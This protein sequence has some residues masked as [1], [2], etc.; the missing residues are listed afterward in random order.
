MEEIP[1]FLLMAI[2]SHID[3][4]FGHTNLAKIENLRVVRIIITQTLIKITGFIE[5]VDKTT[6][7]FLGGDLLACFESLR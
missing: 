5:I 4:Y 1:I 2:S 3:Q 6:I 7:A